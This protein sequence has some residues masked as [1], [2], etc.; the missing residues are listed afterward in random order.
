MF[1]Y[2]H[3]KATNW[4]NPIGIILTFVTLPVV[5]M[6]DLFPIVAITEIVVGVGCLWEKF[7]K[8]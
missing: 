7:N 1:T 5:I 4:K 3:L 2:L 8:R 6:V